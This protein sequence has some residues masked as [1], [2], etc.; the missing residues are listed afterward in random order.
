MAHK[1]ETAPPR[2]APSKPEAVRREARGE[3][4]TEEQEKKNQALVDKTAT[5]KSKSL[6]PLPQADLKVT[7][8]PTKV[9][10]MARPLRSY[11]Y[12]SGSGKPNRPNALILFSGR[13]RAGSIQ[14]FLD[15]YGHHR[16][17]TYRP[18]G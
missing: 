9:K 2:S 5:A 18:T 3:R 15:G 7:M 4:A 10:E 14:E 8:S 13:S 12:W 17:Q 11:G 1:E 6:K 16:T